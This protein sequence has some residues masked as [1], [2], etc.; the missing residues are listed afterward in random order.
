MRRF[1]TPVA[2][3]AAVLLA[4]CLAACGDD[5]AGTAPVV[6]SSGGDAGTA[7]SGSGA[8]PVTVEHAKGATTF[9]S[10]PERIVTLNV[11]W[12]DAVLAM[13]VQPIAYLLDAA[14]GETG[15]YPWQ[16]DAVA[17]SERIDASGGVP[18]EKIAALH[19]DLILVTYLAEEPGVYD[20][21]AAIAP[22]IG[23]LGDLQVD[24]W[25]D[26][27]TA[28]GEVLGDPAKAEAV[29][30]GV[31]AKVQALAEELPGLEGA[32]YA[33]A[34]YVPGDGIYVIADPD[35]G[36]SRFFYAL[37]MQIAPDILALDEAAV[38]RVEISFE[39]VELLDAD[40][41][42]I[43]ANGGDPTTLPGWSDLTAVR[44]DAVAE[45]VFADVVGLNTP[46]PLSLPYEI[47]LLRPVL[48]T[49]ASVAR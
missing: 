12:T 41:L 35:D 17:S 24:P 46:T 10:R 29:V 6:A 4:V 5:D 34:N 47:D 26:Q 30:A 31:E 15:P 23:L 1:R 28:L 22:T 38:G 37:G 20:T 11:Q 3:L 32:T 45:F 8:Y 25:Q 2:L 33:M 39:Q 48:E 9:E 16:V 36:A 7:P 42:A 21:L 44:N 13:G 49:V 27:V 14:S 43:L 19:P 40:L 18:F